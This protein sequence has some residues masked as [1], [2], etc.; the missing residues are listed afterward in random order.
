MRLATL[1]VVRRPRLK[2]PRLGRFVPEKIIY[3][4]HFSSRNNLLPV[5]ADNSNLHRFAGYEPY[6]RPFL[7]GLTVSQVHARGGAHEGSGRLPVE[8]PTEISDPLWQVTEG[9]GLP[10]QWPALESWKPLRSLNLPPGHR[11]PKKYR[12]GLKPRVALHRRSRIVAGR[13]LPV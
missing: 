4:N 11:Q 8:Q 9:S 6:N 5:R 3:C 7:L 13:G 2:S 12:E 1:W 10:N